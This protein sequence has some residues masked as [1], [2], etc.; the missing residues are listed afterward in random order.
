[1]CEWEAGLDHFLYLTGYMLRTVF[2]AG[3]ALGFTTGLPWTVRYSKMNTI[4]PASWCRLQSVRLSKVIFWTGA[5]GRK[6][7]WTWANMQQPLYLHHLH[8]LFVS[9]LPYLSL[10]HFCTWASEHSKDNE[11]VTVDVCSWQHSVKESKTRNNDRFVY[12]E[13]SSIAIKKLFSKS[14]VG[15]KLEE[16]K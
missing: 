10:L 6:V 3:R 1:M 15:G 5:V 2:V 12:E 4:A 9:A 11:L 8:F 16:T 14:L 7:K 13:K